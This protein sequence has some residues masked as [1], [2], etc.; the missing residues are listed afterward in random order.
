M[1]LPCANPV[2]ESK[3]SQDS[4]HPSLFSSASLADHEGK[5]AVEP[6]CPVTH[7]P[8]PTLWYVLSPQVLVR[9]VVAR[10]LPALFLGIMT[11][12][13][14]LNSFSSSL[15]VSQADTSTGWTSCADFKSWKIDHKSNKGGEHGL[16]W[17]RDV[18]STAVGAWG[19]QQAH[20]PSLLSAIIPTKK[21]QK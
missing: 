11:I 19:H 10:F 16:F 12:S 3:A 6:F 2:H 14:L 18:V 7:T 13:L 20:T 17:F 5:V 4:A 8:R 21:P 15:L 9:M 1:N